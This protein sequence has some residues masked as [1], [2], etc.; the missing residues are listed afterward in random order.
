MS[1]RTIRR[2]M[3]GHGVRFRKML[4]DVLRREAI[5]L[6]SDPNLSIAQIADRLG[7]SD[8]ANFTRSCKRRTSSAPSTS[9]PET[10]RHASE[11]GQ[12]QEAWPDGLET[13][14]KRV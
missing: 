3:A 10:T 7:Y 13:A 9:R 4:D 2:K 8:P 1:P 6:L 12:T 14:H 11:A 5:K